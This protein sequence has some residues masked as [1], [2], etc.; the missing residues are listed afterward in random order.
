LPRRLGCGARRRVTFLHKRGLGVQQV[1]NTGKL[2]GG[3]VRNYAL[4]GNPRKL[5]FFQQRYVGSPEKAGKD[6]KIGGC[7]AKQAG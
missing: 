4:A 5:A 6:R 3:R 7:G 2:T 1:D